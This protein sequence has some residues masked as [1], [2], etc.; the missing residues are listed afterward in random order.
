MHF[1]FS[2]LKE[3]NRFLA[4]KV[5]FFLMLL[6][7]ANK[8]IFKFLLIFKVFGVVNRSGFEAIRIL[9]HIPVTIF[10]AHKHSIKISSSQHDLTVL[11]NYYIFIFFFDSNSYLL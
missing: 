4:Y 7:F 3:K 2:V 1:I 9:K 11:S 5:Y 10:C 6:Y 8:Q